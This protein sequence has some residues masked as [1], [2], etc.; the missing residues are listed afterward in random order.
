MA[1][2][3]GRLGV[4]LNVPGAPDCP[5]VIAT[6][7]QRG[8]EWRPGVIY[9]LDE[10]GMGEDAVLAWIDQNT[11][12]ARTDEFVGGVKTGRTFEVGATCPL[13]LVPAPTPKEG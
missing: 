7:P 1:A 11:P 2:P 4:G 9:P 10:L 13:E 6:W 8:R 5:L 12:A 3:K